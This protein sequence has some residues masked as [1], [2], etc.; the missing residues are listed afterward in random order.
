MLVVLRASDFDFSP[1]DGQTESDFYKQTFVS[2][3]IKH[4]NKFITLN[5]AS[6]ALCVRGG[7]IS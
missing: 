7:Q 3:L 2:L 6:D 1:S 5:H 4:I